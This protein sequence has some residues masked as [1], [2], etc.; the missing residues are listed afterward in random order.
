MAFGV[1]FFL[2]SPPQFIWPHE[3]IR[4][5]VSPCGRQGPGTAPFTSRPAASS[6]PSGASCRPTRSGPR[7]PPAATPTLHRTW[8][9]TSTPRPQRTTPARAGPCTAAEDLGRLPSLPKLHCLISWISGGVKRSNGVTSNEYPSYTSHK[10]TPCI[11]FFDLSTHVELSVHTLK[12]GQPRRVFAFP[13]LGRGS[14]P[15]EPPVPRRSEP[16]YPSPP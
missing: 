2:P 3:D 14:H 7:P 12:F 15:S 5:G 8:S 4:P 9:P 6:R 16:I 11:F 10:R 1:V 13:C